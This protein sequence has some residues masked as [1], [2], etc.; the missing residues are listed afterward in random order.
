MLIEHYDLKVYP[1]CGGGSLDAV[2]GTARY[3]FPRNV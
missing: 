3:N 2:K 1:C